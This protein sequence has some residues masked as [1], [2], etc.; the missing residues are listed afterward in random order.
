MGARHG[1][2]GQDKG[3][4]PVPHALSWPPNDR[5]GSKVDFGR[6]S[7]GRR[8]CRDEGQVGVGLVAV[9]LD[10]SK[11]RPLARH[12]RQNVSARLL[13]FRALLQQR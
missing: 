5:N 10:M 9:V 4:P 3:L 7:L 8:T 13:K 12:V 11:L 1:C 6:D 2:G